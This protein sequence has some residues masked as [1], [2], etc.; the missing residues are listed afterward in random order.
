MT[1]DLADPVEEVPEPTGVRIRPYDHAADV[2]PVHDALEEA[3]VEHWGFE[4][5]PYDFHERE[6][7][8]T[9]PRLVAVAETDGG[10]VGAAIAKAV[11]GS[12]WVD[13]VGVR[14]P[15]RGRGV[16]RALL[17]RE[18]AALAELGMPVASLNVDAE[19]TTGA[20]RLYESAGMRVRRAWSIFEKRVGRLG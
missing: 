4:P 10:I 14:A 15:W 8:Q 5:F 17:L 13:V 7:A 11:E 3:F 9:D 2:R 16:A 19:N 1:R 20:T 12:G 18:F 6:L